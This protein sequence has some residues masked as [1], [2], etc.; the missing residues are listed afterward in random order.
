MTFLITLTSI[1]YSYPPD[2]FS[3]G[4]IAS[5]RV[6]KNFFKPSSTSYNSRL[7]SIYLFKRFFNIC[8]ATFLWIEDFAWLFPSSMI[9]WDILAYSSLEITG[10][11]YVSKLEHNYTTVIESF[12]GIFSR[13]SAVLILI[14]LFY[15]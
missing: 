10:T 6:L 3:S 9:N 13:E 12:R 4:R 14:F 5:Q 1:S 7:L 8:F 2:N 15:F 11:L